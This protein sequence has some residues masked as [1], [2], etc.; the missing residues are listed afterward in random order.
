[1][2]PKN[3]SNS[4]KNNPIHFPTDIRHTKGISIENLLPPNGA[5]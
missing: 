3:K 2:R 4:S 5:L 1:M